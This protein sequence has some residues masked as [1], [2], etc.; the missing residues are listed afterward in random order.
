MSVDRLNHYLQSLLPGVQLQA[1]ALQQCP[2][3]SLYLINPDYPQHALDSSAVARLMDEPPYWGF[4]WASGQVL[5]RYVLDNPEW[6]AGRHV[7][8][9]GAGSGVVGIAAALAGASRVSCVDIDPLAQLSIAANAELNQCSVDIAG[10]MP[11]LP[12]DL[13][14]VADV[15]Y[16]S[17]NLPLLRQLM[18]AAPR[19][20]LA[21]SRI[22]NFRLE[23]FE[24]IG[25]YRSC[26]WPDLDESAEFNQVRLYCAG[27][28]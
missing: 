9:F 1:Q 19:L 23:A 26:T 17:D 6:V 7:L 3:L 22:K 24:Q 13:I 11:E 16:D 28:I 5:A 18:G 2:Q 21:D 8:D 10:V 14:T 12:I 25:E 20:L 15:L 4:C 27:E